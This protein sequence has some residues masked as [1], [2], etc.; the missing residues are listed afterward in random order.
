M[1]SNEAAPPEGS[2][3][4]EARVARLVELWSAR[5][6]AATIAARLGDGI[7]RSAVVGKLFRLGLRRTDEQRYEA[8]AEGARR[9]GARRRATSHLARRSPPPMPVSPLPP[10]SP[11]AVV[12]RL[13]PLPLLQRGACRWPY[14]ADGETRFCGHAAR[15]GR[16]YC[17]DHHA[18]A[19]AEVLPPLTLEALG[20]AATTPAGRSK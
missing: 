17:P 5:L 2:L 1:K 19:Y 11:C 13:V 8:Q 12:P 7:S 3:W 9:T 18:I 20:E 14:E 15:G 6:S 10:P 4:T 16:S